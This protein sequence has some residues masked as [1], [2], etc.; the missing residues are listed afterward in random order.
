[1]DVLASVTQVPGVT[2]AAIMDTAG[3]CQQHRLQPPLEPILLTEIV[4]FLRT[5]TDYYSG[6][7]GEE[8]TA[9]VVNYSEGH[10]V[11]RSLEGRQIIVIC[12][13]G[14]NLSMVT[15]SV[16]AA[17]LKLKRESSSSPPQIPAGGSNEFASMPD[18][19]F[20]RMPSF[21][22]QSVT[23]SMS[24]D[25]RGSMPPPGAVGMKVM[26]HV[27]DTFVNH[28]GPRGKAILESELRS[29]GTSPRKLGAAHFADLIRRLSRYVEDK[30]DRKRFL[31]E[32]LGDRRGR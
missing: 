2:G 32:V 3:Q 22:P 7:D 5:A 20:S 25:D 16:N 13:K 23:H 8:M 15:V 9:L 27:L 14:A 12:S 1:M 18:S 10:I 28:I 11:V 19:S 26:L 4:T 29:L 17:V 21:A 6:L 24:W 31:S 30:D